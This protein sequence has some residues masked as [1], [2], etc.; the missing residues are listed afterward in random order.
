MLS[1]RHAGL[2]AHAALP[3]RTVKK[4]AR[5]IDCTRRNDQGDATRH[6]VQ[7]AYDVE[8]VVAIRGN[9]NS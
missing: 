3:E 7:R 6:G 5:D 4:P 9:P 1:H 8:A 2:R